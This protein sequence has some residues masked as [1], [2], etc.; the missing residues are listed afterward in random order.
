MPLDHA[1]G[2]CF[3]HPIQLRAP[4]RILK[5]RERRLGGEHC[6]ADRIAIDQELVDR[7]I[8]E[9]RGIVPIR[10]AAG[11]PKEPLPQQ[12]PHR[13]LYLAF[14]AAIDQARGQ[15]L[16]QSQRRIAGLQQDRPAVRAA[17]ALIELSP[18]WLGKQIRKQDRLSCA[19]FN[20][21]KAS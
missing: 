3:T 10:V 21:A 13:V 4:C 19:I 2:E 6:S 18:Q 5:A 9:P 16:R 11:D 8:P 20:H 15:P 1:L 7:I 14:L 17:M 12:I